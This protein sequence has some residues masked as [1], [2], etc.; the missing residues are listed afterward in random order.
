[1]PVPVIGLTTDRN[2]N[3]RQMVL[4]NT[5]EAYVQA[6]IRAGGIPVLLP[7]GVQTA[8]LAGIAAR[9]DGVIFIGGGDV[10]PNRFDGPPNPRISAV[11][12]QRDELEIELLH[13]LV[14]VGKPFLGICRGLQM[15]N[16]ALGGTL[17][18]DISSQMKDAKRHDWYPN[19]PRNH[20]AHQV[21][22]EKG[23]LLA[24]ITGAG[25]LDVN[26]LHHQGI[27]S[28]APGLKTSGY[29]PD[30]LVEAIQLKG[31]PFGLGVQWH[32]EWLSGYPAHQAIFKALVQ[33]A[34]GQ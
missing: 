28:L 14:A 23:S 5:A 3:P 6:V 10:N 7:I 9:L 25:D 18:T 32:P 8:D 27:D 11:D 2:L 21:T 4:V 16:V 15:I 29:S 24:E 17:Y 19:I 34:A 30:G 22:V 1:M 13:L 33:A 20:I 26:S 31:H 12:D